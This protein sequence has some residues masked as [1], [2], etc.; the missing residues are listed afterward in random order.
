MGDSGARH[1]SWGSRFRRPSTYPA[2]VSEPGRAH[3]RT[4]DG[5]A[6]PTDRTT[7]DD[8]PVLR[9]GRGRRRAAD[10]RAAVLS[11]AGAILF[12][13]GLAQV[14]FDKVAKRAGVSKVTLYR[15]WPSVGALAF[16]AHFAVTERDLAFHDSGDIVADLRAQ[17]LAFVALLVARRDGPVIGELIG[18]AQA[19]PDLAKTLG[20][21][22]TKPR[23]RLA[24]DR[25]TAA[26]RQAQIRRD[27]DP[28]VVVDQLWGACYHRLL[29]PAEPLDEQFVD[30]LLGNLMA[31][32]SE[33]S[34]AV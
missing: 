31:G 2:G 5:S 14:T 15:W 18:A 24:V 16:E 19:D 28:E 6:E 26:Q 25:I 27:V 13:A 12:D 8:G 7:V 21:L 22:Y 29:L 20:E 1:E 17:L 9:P 10:V 3:N 30:A 34:T 23:R 11:A 32:I 4:P 33:P